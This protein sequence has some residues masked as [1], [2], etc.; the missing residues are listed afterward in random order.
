MIAQIEKQDVIEEQVL[1]EKQYID[2]ENCYQQLYKQVRRMVYH[3]RL[4]RWEG[5]EEDV[6]WDIVQESMRKI[7]EYTL[8]AEQGE[9]KPVQ[10]LENLLYVT[11]L[12]CLR[13]R[14]R[15]EKKLC[16]E[17]AYFL[18]S[19]SGPDTRAHLSELATENVYQEGLFYLVAENIAHF[20]P[21]QRGALL[22]DL[23]SRMAF[24]KEPTTLQAAFRAQD[25]RLE[26]YLRDQSDDREE[27]SR[28]AALLYQANQRLRGLKDPR[29]QTYL[30]DEPGEESSDACLV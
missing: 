16:T 2:W 14:R 23:A 21:K 29:L 30:Q 22:M 7:Y 25:I 18:P 1:A 20:P 5:E 11:A 4:P 27:R 26:D 6:I 15:R 3:M 9:E 28:H 12:N 8:R 17:S 24:G 10:E 19:L 13:G